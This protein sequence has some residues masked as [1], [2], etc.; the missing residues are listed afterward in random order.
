MAR[1]AGSPRCPGGAVLWT[2]AS[3]ND[4]AATNRPRQPS[5][6]QLNPQQHR[7]RQMNAKRHAASLLLGVLLAACVEYPGHP[8]AGRFV[9]SLPRPDHDHYVGADRSSRRRCRRPRSR[10][11]DPRRHPMP[12]PVPPKPTGATFHEDV[13]CLDAGCNEAKTTQTVTWRTPRTKGVTIRVYGVTE[14]LAQTGPPKAGR[15]RAMPRHAHASCRRRSAGCS[16]RPRRSAGQ[17]SWSWT[18]GDRV[19][20]QP[21]WLSTPTGPGTSPSFVAAYNASGQS[22]FTI[23][24]PGQWREASAWRQVY[25]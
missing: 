3:A 23:A 21:V 14:C 7:R 22:I 17:V 10:P 6:R 25:C 8:N 24:E 9:A 16:P 18:A 13:N 20:H 11:R 5:H 19:R 2:S 12:V 1:V 15:E 4:W